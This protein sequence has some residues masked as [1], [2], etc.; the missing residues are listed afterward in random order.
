[1]E[2]DKELKDRLLLVMREESQL[3]DVI[4]KQQEVVHSLVLKRKWLELENVLKE[5]QK[6]SDNFTELD[7]KRE[8]LFSKIDVSGDF[9]FSSAVS[10]VKSKLIKSKLQNKVLNE[11]IST[12]KDFLQ[13][14]FDEV[15]PERRNVTYSRYGKIVKP[16]LHNV[17]IN[18]VV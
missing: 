10:Q 1:M 15:L 8:E 2:N 16:E 11:Y 3:L 4:L 9:E 17:V 6:M 7:N 12:T 5:L 13:G 18:Q 14:I